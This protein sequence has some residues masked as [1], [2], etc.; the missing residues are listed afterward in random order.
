M[1][2]LPSITCDNY[3]CLCKRLFKPL[4]EQALKE[5][6]N[7]VKG[8]CIDCVK[9]SRDLEFPNQTERKCRIEHDRVEVA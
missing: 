6:L 8:L 3:Q 9:S 5:Q 7:K 4:V 1:N 2:E